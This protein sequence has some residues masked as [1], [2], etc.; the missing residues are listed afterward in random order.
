MQSKFKRLRQQTRRR[1]V[2]I[3]ALNHARSTPV[4]SRASLDLPVPE[5]HHWPR[6]GT[7]GFSTGAGRSFVSTCSPRSSL[8]QSAQEAYKT[9]IASL[10]LPQPSICKDEAMIP[11][12]CN[13]RLNAI[14]YIVPSAIVHDASTTI[15][16]LPSDGTLP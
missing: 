7:C 1:T 12:L 15:D 13:H 5:P 3:R 14:R 9:Y 4:R 10:T 8:M 6:Q 2:T 16:T 11:S